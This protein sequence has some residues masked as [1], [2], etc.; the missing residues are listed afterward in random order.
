[1]S[2][3]A[4]AVP[5]VNYNGAARGHEWNAANGNNQG[6]L[7]QVTAADTAVF[8]MAVA[9]CCTDQGRLFVACI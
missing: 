7:Y 4:F 1:M 3:P 5:G 8:R 6:D 2:D 9:D